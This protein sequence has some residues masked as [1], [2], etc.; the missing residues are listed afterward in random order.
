MPGSDLQPVH[1]GCDQVHEDWV[2]PIVDEAG[3]ISHAVT[4]HHCHDV[5]GRHNHQH[6]VS[7]SAVT[8]GAVRDDMAHL[9]CAGR[10]GGYWKVFII[11]TGGGA[12]TWTPSSSPSCKSRQ[13]IAARS[14]ELL[15]SPP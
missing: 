11:L 7:G 15:I 8:V 3:R 10:G 6:A 13:P 9:G 12:R 2:V 4:D 1:G 14:R 5:Q